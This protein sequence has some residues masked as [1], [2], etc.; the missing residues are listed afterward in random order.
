MV[1]ANNRRW[2]GGVLT[3]ERPGAV[4][5]DRT[6][7]DE[8]PGLGPP[9]RWPD[10]CEV[11]CQVTVTV[12]AVGGCA[13]VGAGTPSG[14]A[15]KAAPASRTSLPR[16]THDRLP[17]LSF[18]MRPSWLKSAEARG[19]PLPGAYETTVRPME[20][21]GRASVKPAKGARP[22]RSLCHVRQLV[23]RLPRDLGRQRD[24]SFTPRRLFLRLTLA[25]ALMF[26]AVPSAP[27][28]RPPLWGATSA[29]RRRDGSRGNRL[30]SWTV[31]AALDA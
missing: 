14:P 22:V 23:S 12:S 5:A 21:A 1:K 29:R 11:T 2:Y 30:S 7:R 16:R 18:L 20:P 9:I 25:A 31:A 17:S 3:G 26:T 13:A 15:T 4:V 10:W 27:H 8:H 19:L 24:R 6:A 28:A